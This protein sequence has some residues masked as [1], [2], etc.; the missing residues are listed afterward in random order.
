LWVLFQAVAFDKGNSEFIINI[1]EQEKQNQSDEV[2]IFRAQ[3]VYF[4]L[5]L[6][7]EITSAT[8]LRKQNNL[9]IYKLKA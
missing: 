2:T 9:S 3:T 8:L 7:S 6:D 1:I 4:R 5:M